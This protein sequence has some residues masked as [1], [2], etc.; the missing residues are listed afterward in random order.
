MS[1]VLTWWGKKMWNVWHTGG[2]FSVI[3]HM[4]NLQSPPFFTNC[5]LLKKFLIKKKKKQ[6]HPCINACFYNPN[7][8]LLYIEVKPS[9]LQRSQR[10]PGPAAV[11]KWAPKVTINRSKD[12]AT[13]S[14]SSVIAISRN[15]FRMQLYCSLEKENR[16]LSEQLVLSLERLAVMVAKN[17]RRR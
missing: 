4:S 8:Q 15:L 13:S 14:A 1:S 9:L 12:S 6:R 2:E 11:W 7:L 3:L 17:W 5:L 10:F 16:E